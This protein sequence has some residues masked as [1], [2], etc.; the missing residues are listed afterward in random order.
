MPF[1]IQAPGNY[2]IT[3]RTNMTFNL[4]IT[5]Y[6]S[7]GAIIDLTTYTAKMAIKDAAE[8]LLVTLSTSNGDI[9]LGASAPNI[10]LTL[11]V[12][13]IDLL[14]VG[15]AYYDLVLFDN[16]GSEYCILAGQCNVIQGITP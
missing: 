3:L 15:Q 4:G 14:P 2:T 7:N 9:I 13:N 16:L 12:A 10:S 6:D 8:H 5:W 11:S 1:S